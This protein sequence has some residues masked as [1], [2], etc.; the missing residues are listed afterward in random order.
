M[1]F[2]QRTLDDAAARDCGRCDRCAGPWIDA[3]VPEEALGSAR[4]TL[5]RAG[6]DLDPRAQWPTGMD[7]LG[8]PVRGRIPAGEAMSPGR[9][10]ARVTDLGWGPRVRELLATDQ[11]VP[12]A[13]VR[14]CVRVL[15]EWGW[16]TRPVGIVTVPSRSRPTLVTS[17]AEQLGQIGRLPVLGSLEPV[18]GG[19]VGEPGGNS[20]YRLSGVWERLVVGPQLARA[21][22]EVRGPVLLVD[23][24]A[25]S[26][27]TLTVA[28]R[29]LRQ[30]GVEEVLP[31][32]L[33]LD[34]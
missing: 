1:A 6:V 25:H 23:D 15:A 12:E 28:A 5:D 18:D 8:V 14:A 30:A 34:G 11:P 31:F 27:W 19:P 20:A 3:D 32:V 7:R 29:A 21:L 13:A 2:L 16:T 26:R 9:A 24:V 4:S 33:G 10:L 22:A 17:L